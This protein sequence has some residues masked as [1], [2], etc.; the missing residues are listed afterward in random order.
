MYVSH[1]S[2]PLI[3]LSHNDSQPHTICRL[4]NL[5]LSTLRSTPHLLHTRTFL[6][7]PPSS[8]A[9][10]SSSPR[11]EDDDPDREAKRK[12]EIAESRFRNVT[13][14]VD[15]DVAKAYVALAEGHSP[16]A[17]DR[18]NAELPLKESEYDYEHRQVVKEKRH[19]GK[20]S[21]GEG[22]SSIPTL[23]ERAVDQYM[24]DDEW[25]ARERREGRGVVI[26]RFPLFGGGSSG[27]G[28]EEKGKWGVPVSM[29]W[30][31]SE[32]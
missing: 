31:E 25:E 20:V 10:S 4:N 2:H 5:P 13:K 15:W 24:D 19:L 8:S 23:E 28:R 27:K 14:E 9:P 11:K 22:N 16:A 21:S 3:H 29:R 26:P 32:R 12:R 18:N 7:L 6:T 17:E 30:R 1:L